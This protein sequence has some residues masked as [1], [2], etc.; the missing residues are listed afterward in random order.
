[1]AYKEGY[2]VGNQ[3]WDGEKFAVK[4]SEP[5][6]TISIK[7]IDAEQIEKYNLRV[8]HITPFSNK[9]IVE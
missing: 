5:V 7:D 2:Q 9:R 3:V 4:N 6:G 8:G 1:M